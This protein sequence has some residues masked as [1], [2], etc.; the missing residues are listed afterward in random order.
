MD[1]VRPGDIV[2]LKRGV[3]QIF[4]VGQVTD[5]DGRCRSRGDKEWL[6]DFDGWDLEASCNV[7]WHI[8]DQPIITTGLTR[9]T[10]QRVNQP[11]LTQLADQTIATIKKSEQYESSPRQRK[12]SG[13]T[14]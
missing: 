3:T 12:R 6:R 1:E 7:D 4:A 10:I 8:L 2:I 9:A 13:M 5:R 11:H 14:I